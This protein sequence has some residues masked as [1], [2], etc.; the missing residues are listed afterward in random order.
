MFTTNSPNSLRKLLLFD[1]ATCAAMGAA[2]VL[3][4]API[5]D[6]TAIPSAIL[7]YSGVLL[8]PIAAFM[9]VV[10]TRAI[11][12]TPALWLIIVGNA[13]W[14]A[15]SLALMLGGWIAPNALGYAF[16]GAQAAAVAVLAALEYG[17]L[18]RSSPHATAEVLR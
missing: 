15:A 6:W 2:L 9:A 7:S 8:L 14:V 3:G 11:A 5:A 17:A 12:S 16:I 4:A 1:A 13:L 18:R 10:A